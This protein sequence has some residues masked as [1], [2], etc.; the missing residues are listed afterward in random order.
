MVRCISITGIVACPLCSTSR[1]MSAICFV[2]ILVFQP[3][4]FGYCCGVGCWGV[5]FQP[6]N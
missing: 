5:V 4:K 2:S 3:G 6:G 1:M